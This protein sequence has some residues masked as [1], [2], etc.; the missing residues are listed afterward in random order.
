[1]K[2]IIIL[3][4][5]LLLT[6]CYNYKEVSDLAFISSFSIDYTN[7]NEFNIIL[8]IKEN[9]K[10]NL[11]SSYLLEGYGK[12]IEAAIQ[13]AS[14]S[15]NKNLY[16]INLDILLISSNAANLKLNNIL[17]YVTRDNNFA[18]DFNI[19]ICDDSK[20]AIENILKKEEIFGRYI[21]TLF[22]NTDNNVINIKLNDLLNSYLNHYYDIILPIINLKDNT[23][24]IDEA[25]IFKNN[26]IIEHLNEKEISIYNILSNNLMDYYIHL[27]LDNNIVF[28]T[29]HYNTKT[30]FKN[31]TLYIIPTLT[32][33][34]IEFEN[35][36]LNNSK[37]LKRIT[38]KINAKFNNEVEAFIDNLIKIESDPL[39]LKR[40]IKQ[41]SL[42]KIKYRISTN[43]V[44]ENKSLIFKSIG[45]K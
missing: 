38:E 13:N 6:G 31:N 34:Y 9:N 41:K 24:I 19:A 27:E 23:I 16:F 40:Y 26:E 15:F 14:L 1:M 35:L 11:F 20:G 39:G 44:L 28:K 5:I 3:T 29:T 7:N 8:E 32:G 30:N 42:H 2:K 33:S 4:I 25:V 12:T 45:G 10:D 22:K 43:I 36:N 37:E 21:N 18:L 17:D